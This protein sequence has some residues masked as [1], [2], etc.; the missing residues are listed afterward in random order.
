M[1]MDRGKASVTE[2]RSRREWRT[3]GKLWKRKKGKGRVGMKRE[4]RG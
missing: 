4:E 1:W 3:E 2:K